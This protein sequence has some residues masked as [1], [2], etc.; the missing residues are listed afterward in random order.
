MDQGGLNLISVPSKKAAGGERQFWSKFFSPH[1]SRSSVQ[2]LDGKCLDPFCIRLQRKRNDVFILYWQCLCGKRGGDSHVALRYLFTRT[3]TP[4]NPAVG[5]LSRKH[6]TQSEPPLLPL[7]NPNLFL[8]NLRFTQ[9]RL[10]CQISILE[11]FQIDLTS[12][13][14]TIPVPIS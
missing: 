2:S 11:H 3:R 8:H 9:I 12:H 1:L 13:K 4:L 5:S 14:L 6:D 7:S 10:I